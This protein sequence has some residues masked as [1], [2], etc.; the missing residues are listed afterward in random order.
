VPSRAAL[1]FHGIVISVNDS[2]QRP[3]QG[4]QQGMAAQKHAYNNDPEICSW[5][6][7][8]RGVA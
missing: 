1:L 5:T 3:H 8:S 7:E 2:H 6:L 4:F